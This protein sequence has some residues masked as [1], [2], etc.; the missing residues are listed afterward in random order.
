MKTIASLLFVTV[1]GNVAAFGQKANDTVTIT[2]TPPGAAVE[3]NRKVI[4]VTPLTCKVGE[5]AFNAHKSSLFSK[6]LD[7]PVNLHITLTGFNAVDMTITGGPLVWTSFNRKTSFTYFVIGLQHFN[8]TL[9]KVSDAPNTITNSDVVNLHAAGFGDDVI[10]GK[11]DTTATAFRLQV[12]DMVELRRAGVSDA[13]IQAMLK[14]STAHFVSDSRQ[15]PN[16]PKGEAP[17]AGGWQLFEE[18]ALEG[19]ISGMVQPGRI[20]KTTSGSVY[21][22]TGLT[23]QLVLELQPEVTVL[24]NGNVYKLVVKGFEEPLLCRLLISVTSP[25]GSPP[26]SST[27]GVI[28]TQIDDDFEGWDG[29]TIFKLSNGQIWQQAA[30]AYT[31]HY[32]YRPKVLIY[33][34]GSAY[35]MKVE[36]VDSSILVKRLK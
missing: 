17:P 24:R 8:F 20:L 36:G 13:V 30:Y 21:E 23:L 1:A 2:T 15:I 7:Q 6:H 35:R 33:L 26:P 12:S 22:V 4:G 25:K 31:Y 11:I 29:E 3:W 9:D 19:S 32:A 27:P 34:S 14:K 28:E 5:Y 16:S 18:T 10:I